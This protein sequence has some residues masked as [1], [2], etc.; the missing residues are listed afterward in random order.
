MEQF[1]NIYLRNSLTQFI[2]GT[3]YT[4][5]ISVAI[6]KGFTPVIKKV[7]I[8]R[9]IGRLGYCGSLVIST[10]PQQQSFTVF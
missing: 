1:G 3:K 10:G 6:S 9:Q 7:E 2:V 5:K 4:N 8:R